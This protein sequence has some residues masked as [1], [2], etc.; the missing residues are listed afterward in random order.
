MQNVCHCC[1][2]IRHHYGHLNAEFLSLLDLIVSYQHTP[3]LFIIFF[4]HVHVEFEVKVRF[5]NETIYQITKLFDGNHNIKGGT[6]DKKNLDDFL[7]ILERQ[8][9]NLNFCVSPAKKPERRLKHYFKKLIFFFNY[10]PQS[11]ELIRK[12]TKRHLQRLD[13]IIGQFRTVLRG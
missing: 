5:L 6:R 12:E 9:E 1:D 7:N 3:I 2:W 10:S 13:M 11:W 8:F 4:L